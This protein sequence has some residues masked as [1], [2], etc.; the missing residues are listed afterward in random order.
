[1]SFVKFASA[2]TFYL[3]ESKIFLANIFL[4]KETPM[5]RHL[6]LVFMLCC[7]VCFSSASCSEEQ[8]VPSAIQL[9]SETEE[10]SEPEKNNK[11]MES[12]GGKIVKNDTSGTLPLMKLD[13]K[14]LEKEIFDWGANKSEDTF[15]E[16]LTLSE[17]DNVTI[18]NKLAEL[19]YLG[20]RPMTWDT[21]KKLLQT[22]KSISDN[23]VEA[24]SNLGV[25]YWVGMGV[26]EAIEEARKWDQLAAEQG[27]EDA[28]KRL[29]RGYD[30]P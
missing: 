22:F 19:Y 27:D 14:Q 24:Q 15:V 16:L 30:G 12:T 21:S 3:W 23:N 10:S 26:K 5:K 29:L 17:N 2:L 25:M 9:G 6:I 8:S 13:R 18:K 4:R 28:Q 20:V 1:M 11:V 7:V